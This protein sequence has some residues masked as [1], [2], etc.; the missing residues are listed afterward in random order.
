MAEPLPQ[1][2]KRP[3]HGYQY[4]PEEQAEKDH[5]IKQM[6]RD[7]M[8][9][10]LASLPEAGLSALAGGPPMDA[11]TAAI[12][13]MKCQ[14]AKKSS[15]AQPHGVAP[16]ASAPHIIVR[17]AGANTKTELEEDSDQAILA[18]VSQLD[19]NA[20]AL[21]NSLATALES[22]GSPSN[23]AATVEAIETTGTGALPSDVQR[24]QLR[25]ER[26]SHT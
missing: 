20:K 16:A 23:I 12:F 8:S 6:L 5:Y 17:S 15:S 7:F 26:A 21:V 1:P 3:L 19:P 9:S 10:G 11:S 18:A 14:Q 25:V 4:S 22:D 24:L 2:T 13:I